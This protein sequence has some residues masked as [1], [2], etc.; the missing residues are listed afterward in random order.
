MAFLGHIITNIRS[1]LTS[2][3]RVVTTY[4]DLCPIGEVGDEPVERG[5]VRGRQSVRPLLEQRTG[6]L[7]HVWVYLGLGIFCQIG[8]K[9]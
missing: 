7:E 2:D 1:S 3:D 8:Q 5:V 9:S 6:M 4:D